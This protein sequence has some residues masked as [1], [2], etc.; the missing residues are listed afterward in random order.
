MEDGLDVD[1]VLAECETTLVD[2][3]NLVTTSPEA[4]LVM[5]EPVLAKLC[6]VHDGEATDE[7]EYDPSVG[8]LRA[9]KEHTIK[10]DVE[11]VHVHRASAIVLRERCI[12]AMVTANTKL[13]R[14]QALVELLDRVRPL[15]SSMPKAKTAK[16]VR[17]VIDALGEI[18][19][20]EP[21]QVRLCDDYIAWS[22]AEK[23]TFLR[24]RIQARLAQLLLARGDNQQALAILKDL[25]SEVKRID[26]KT[27]LVEVFLLESQGWLALKNANKAKGSLTAARSAANTIYVLPTLQAQIDMQ[28]GMLNANDKDYRIAYSYFYEAFTALSDLADNAGATK[29]LKYMVLCKIMQNLGDDL[30]AIFN[31]K[32]AVKH[33]GPDMEA[34]RQVAR[35]YK[36]RSLH[37]FDAVLRQF[38]NELTGDVLVSKHLNDLQA[39]LLEN[40]L[41]RI[42]EPFSHVEIA[43][44]AELIN[45]P[46]QRVEAKLAQ[47]ILDKK[48]KGILDHGAGVLVVFDE[49]EPDTTY[50]SALDVI[51]KMG[52]V[53]QSLMG[54][55]QSL[56]A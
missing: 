37:E 22:T 21:L 38:P 31:S 49:P 55:A 12:Y 19:G 3:E 42:I 35:A 48:L 45:L 13:Q 7:P 16:I 5:L 15:F 6:S 26:D 24:Q 18:P 32:Q 51:E 14:A 47:M 2:A 34:M 1:P 39:T 9:Q 28:G 40:N 53:V 29:A 36:E 50:Q 46:L 52:G 41:V 4:A 43:R 33:L 27:L 30:P 8:R 54:R 25:Q 20:S 56:V 44:V 11:R 10:H 23:R 17:V